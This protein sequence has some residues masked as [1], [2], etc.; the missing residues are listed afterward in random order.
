LIK[1]HLDLQEQDWHYL[2]TNSV[3]PS[4]FHRKK[5]K[6]QI[7]V[8]DAKR[9]AFDILVKLNLIYLCAAI[10]SFGKIICN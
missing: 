9:N 4:Y 5:K 3:S 7:H 8:N 10:A 2:I 1:L 6:D